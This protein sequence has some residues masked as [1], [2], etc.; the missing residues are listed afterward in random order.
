MAFPRESTFALFRRKLCL[1]Y[2][3]IA[4]GYHFHIAHRT[5]NPMVVL[6]Y[7]SALR[8]SGKDAGEFLH[9]QLSADVMALLPGESTFACYCEP[10]GRVL[11]LV[12][13][14]RHDDDFFMLMSRSLTESISSRM[15]IYVM[16]SKVEIE[17]L[18]E[19]SILG[20]PANDESGLPADFKTRLTI[21]DS[22]NSFLIIDGDPPVERN[23]V[24]EDAWKLSEMEHGVTWLCSETSAQ[25][26]PQM[27][28][29]DSLGA[30]NFRKGCYPGQEIVARTHY[31]GKVKRH[32]RLLK[33][34][35]VICP[36]P[37][38]KI[39]IFSDNLKQEAV[40]TDCART[41]E[42]GTCLFVVTRMEPDRIVDKIEYQGLVAPVI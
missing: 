42:G 31:L 11:A 36:N 9:N 32:P 33:T 22:E 27:L 37:L 3:I 7:L 25:F 5:L 4:I 40:I 18:D 38:E 1:N 30:V 41:G 35:A 26:L 10:K 12:L 28:G 34:T 2:A 23:P 6:P 8:F 14:G 15:K 39:D 21:P 13:V 29:Y 19:C 16:R 20:L 17:R 24:L